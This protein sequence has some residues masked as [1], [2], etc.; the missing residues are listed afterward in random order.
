ML[1]VEEPELVEGLLLLSYPLHPPRKPDELRTSHFPKLR[2]PTF[3]V[4]GTRDPFGTIAEMQSALKLIPA[5]HAIFEVESAGHDLW[6]KKT[7]GDLPVQIVL[8]F[9]SF[10]DKTVV[11]RMIAGGGG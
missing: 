11:S 6:S 8:A 3:F 2:K 9:Q 1:L 7:A 5:Q 4:H 10:V